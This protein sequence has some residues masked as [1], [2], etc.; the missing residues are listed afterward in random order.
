MYY[1]TTMHVLYQSVS[2]SGCAINEQMVLEYVGLEYCSTSTRASSA[3]VP[4]E[5]F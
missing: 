3:R 4:S 5:I 2:V 1:T